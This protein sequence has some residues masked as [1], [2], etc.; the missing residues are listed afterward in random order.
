MEYKVTEKDLI[1]DIKDFPIEV[2]KKMIE[3]Q[4]EQ[5]NNPNVSVFQD[6]LSM[7]RIGGGFDWDKT[8]Y[9][10]DFWHSVINEHKFDLFFE[11]YSK[12]NQVTIENNM[13]TNNIIINGITLPKGSEAKVTVEDGNTIITFQKQESEVE[14]PK[15]KNGD[16]IYVQERDGGYIAIFQN[17]WDD[18]INVHASLCLKTGLV[19][20]N[21]NGKEILIRKNILSIRYAAD[22]EK[23]ELFNKLAKQKQLR[24][25]EKEL[26]F[27]EYRW[28]AEK[29]EKFWFISGFGKV[30]C[31]N[32]NR[33]KYSNYDYN[34]R[35]YFQTEEL[36]NKALP[37]WKEFFK[38]L[39]L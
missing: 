34:T 10:F 38:S 18:V 36:A 37:K 29:G 22:E 5:G 30:S 21:L 16:I 3:R 4:A 31:W 15:F 25:D 6:A 33:D 39:S 28:R 20:A 2:V 32:D 17:M 23:Q 19:Y 35:N 9:G 13:E 1:G 7:A 11:K 12:E 24:W 27:E 26:K 8:E 14:E